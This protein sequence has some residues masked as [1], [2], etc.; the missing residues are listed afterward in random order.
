MAW[1]ASVS[2]A[3]ARARAHPIHVIQAFFFIGTVHC[4]AICCQFQLLLI[5]SVAVAAPTAKPASDDGLRE[6]YD[7]YVSKAGTYF[8]R[9]AHTELPPVQST[10]QVDIEYVR[11]LRSLLLAGP[12]PACPRSSY[13]LALQV[14]NDVLHGL[15][16]TLCFDIL[17]C[18]CS[19]PFHNSS[20]S[21]RDSPVHTL[22]GTPSKAASSRTPS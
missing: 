18:C 12:L 22:A 6:R 9:V 21:K 20:F 5:M 17:R 4:G 13:W 16:I 19:M 11:L 3:R 7:R 15:I 10:D 1:H 8:D 2:S 14:V